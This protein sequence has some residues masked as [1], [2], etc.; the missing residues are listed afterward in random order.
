MNREDKEY[1]SSKIYEEGIGYTFED[2]SDF[3]DIKDEKFHIL[4]L[5]LL[6]SIKNLKDYINE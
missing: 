2:Y 4:R 3:E 6:K 5:E 1:I